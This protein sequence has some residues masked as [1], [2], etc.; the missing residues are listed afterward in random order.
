MDGGQRAGMAA[1]P[2]PRSLPSWVARAMSAAG[3]NPGSG[4]LSAPVVTPSSKCWFADPNKQLVLPLGAAGRSGGPASAPEETT[5]GSCWF[6]SSATSTPAAATTSLPHADTTCPVPTG[7]AHES[8][9]GSD[10]SADDSDTDDEDDE[11]IGD[12]G[13]GG[14]AAGA[15]GAAPQLGKLCG[16]A[17]FPEGNGSNACWDWGNILAAQKWCCPCTD[18]KNCIGM[19]R[20]KPEELLLHRKEYQT[21]RSANR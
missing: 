21:T 11:D 8:L 1:T 17:Q 10:A 4:S 15:A 20:L 2:R 12:E 9:C 19:D 5:T 13:G 16:P 3:S 14:E 6:R 18:R 7:A